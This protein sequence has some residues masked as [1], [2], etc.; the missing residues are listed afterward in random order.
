MAET[1]PTG[2]QLLFRSAQTGEHVL[3]AYL[4]AAERGGRTLPDMMA[5]VFDE[6]GNLLLPL[7]NGQLIANAGSPAA[8][9]VKVGAEQN[10]LSSPAAGTLAI[11]AD[12]QEVAR[13]SAAGLQITGTLSATGQLT[14]NSA[15]ISGTLTV[16][17]AATLNSITLAQDPTQDTQAATKRY[18]DTQLAATAAPISSALTTHTTNTSNPHATTAAQV[19]AYTTAE[20]DTALALKA[21]LASPAFTGTPTAPTQAVG[22]SSTRLATTAFVISNAANVAPLVAGTAATGTSTRYAR[23]D[24]VHPTDGTRVA[25]AGDT[26]TGNL[27]ISKES[28][29]LILDKPADSSFITL[30][31]R[32]SGANRWG[33]TLGDNVAEGASNT[34]SNFGV[35]RYAND[36]TSIDRPL[37]ILRETGVAVFTAIPEGPAADPTTAN[38]LPRKAYVD[39]RMPSG[40]IIMWSGSIA[41]IPAGWALCDGTNG[42]PDL[43][44]RFVIGAGGTRTPATTGGA[45][46]ATTSS[47]G[48]HS[49][50]G[51]TGGTALTTAQLPAHTH[52]GTTSEAGSHRH[53]EGAHVEFG[54]GDFI[55]ATNRN[56]GAASDGER[57]YTEYAGDH[58]HTFTTDATGSGEAH[59]HTISSD[60]AHT[61]TVDTLPP[62]YALAFIMKL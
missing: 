56:T 48:A 13:A 14:T 45:A 25:K 7:S 19:G 50:T 42:T 39:A 55:A 10:G 2:E 8:P 57:Y 37:R 6:Q 9:T 17:G 31:G 58:T 27:T 24:H 51:T 30:V 32:T 62:F 49:H 23:Q 20:T 60:G 44:D 46:S 35:I 29:F 4:E 53:L 43:R 54:T 22:N 21:N 28:P 11:S 15:T 52:T 38:Q 3:D 5:D 34:G 18:V 36:G 47:A 41:S 61:H 1:R 59:A 26:M 33:I 40:G 12:G 16:S